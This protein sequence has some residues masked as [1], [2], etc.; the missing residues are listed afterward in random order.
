VIWHTTVER[1]MTLLER[2]SRLSACMTRDNWSA[3]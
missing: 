2:G 3:D 1:S